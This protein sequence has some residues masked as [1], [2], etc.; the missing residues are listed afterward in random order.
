MASRS[1]RI[2]RRMLLGSAGGLA[3][4]PLLGRAREARS[5]EAPKRKFVVF[6]TP[7]EPIDEPYWRP[8]GPSGSEFALA[9]AT[10]PD[11]LSELDEFKSNLLMLG[12]LSFENPGFDHAAIGIL[13][14]GVPN[15]YPT[16]DTDQNAAIGGGI[17]LDQ[18]MA[19]QLGESSLVLG[20]R[21]R[22]PNGTS[23]VVYKGARRPVDP[24]DDPSAAFQNVFGEALAPGEDVELQRRRIAQRISVL[25]TA[26]GQLELLKRNLSGDDLERMEHHLEELRALEQRLQQ[27]PTDACEPLAPGDTSS[28]STPES[29]T[30]TALAQMDVMVQALSCSA[31]RIG[32]L[33]LGT[34][35]DMFSGHVYAPELA[36]DLGSQHEHVDIVH[37]WQDHVSD[38]VELE[39]V[40]YWLF[41]QFLSRL[42]QTPDGDGSLLDN[43]VVL[44]CKCLGKAH[45]ASNMMFMLAGGKNS[46]IGKLGKF[47]DLGGRKH[48]DLLVSCLN[49]MDVPDT[50]FGRADWNSGALVL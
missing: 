5:A 40:Y 44:W 4:L 27:T 6:F 32:V 33:Q 34:A 28:F 24:Y 15:E 47:V 17:S 50:S 46:G 49:L 41:K 19:E 22:S 3:A 48:N 45:G 29:A 23:R 9:D 8:Q 35:G 2:T 14:T 26:A 42:S 21:S 36:I 38:R 37:G 7:S 16:G 39:R 30:T 43:T 25:D 11:P 18:Y 10:L 1:S 12:D 20:V 31:R 13:L